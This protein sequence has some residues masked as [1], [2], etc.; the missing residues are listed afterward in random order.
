VHGQLNPD[1]QP[2]KT[3]CTHTPNHGI[4]NNNEQINGVPIYAKGANIIPFHTLPVNATPALIRS[5]LAAAAD[6]R[7]NM[8][9]VWGGGWYMPDMFYDLADEMGLLVWQETMF[10]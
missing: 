7:M 5:T 2:P 10:A 8:L 4:V 6:S 9:R 1:H 3:T